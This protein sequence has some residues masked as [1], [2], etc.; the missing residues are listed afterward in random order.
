MSFND[1]GVSPDVVDLLSKSSITQPTAIQEQAIPMLLEDERD[2]I[3]LA[4]TGTGKTLAFGIPIMELTDPFLNRTQSIVVAPTRELAQQISADL[5]AINI[6]GKEVH[7]ESVY[8]GTSVS[9]QIKDLKRKTPQ[10]LVA[11]PGRLIDMLER[12]VLKIDEIQRV[13]LDEADEMLNMGFKEDIYKIL[14]YTPEEK[15]IWLLSATMAKEI[16]KITKTFMKDPFEIRIN[17][18]EKVNKNIDHIYSMVRRENKTRAIERFI[19]ANP[20]MYGIVFCRTR[21]DTQRLADELLS[22][23]YAAEALHGDLSQAQRDRV[24]KKFKNRSLKLLV[25]TDVAA[26]GLDVEDVTHVIHHSLPDD[27]EYYTHRSGRTARAGKKGVSLILINGSELRKMTSLEHQLKI[28]ISE[29]KIPSLEE[30]RELRIKT[31][32][33]D[34]L[35]TEI[36]SDISRGLVDNI[37]KKFEGLSKEELINRIMSREFNKYLVQDNDDLN[38]KHDKQEKMALKNFKGDRFFINLGKKDR[39]SKG[40]LIDFIC[41]QGGI[42]RK[43]IG[44]VTMDR[45]HSFFEVDKKHSKTISD[46]FRNKQHKGRPLRVNRHHVKK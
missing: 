21:M 32:A 41:K 20:H 37:S 10:V 35:K 17:Q 33:V 2:M 5:K 42:S 15:R 40:E 27:Q 25:A 38:V 18:E 23:G 46:R 30:I 26:R 4:Q 16:K 24:T 8:G 39:F 31:W 13:V 3:G 34:I 29:T 44:M 7:I 6:H 11:T 9:Q 22:K 36:N 28:H 1:L 14:S 19:E 12:K 43:Y 45:L